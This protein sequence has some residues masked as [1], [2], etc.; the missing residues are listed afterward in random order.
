M[1]GETTHK[2]KKKRTIVFIYYLYILFF[3][4]LRDA[5]HKNIY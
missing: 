1:F 4:I 2:F 5:L 3:L